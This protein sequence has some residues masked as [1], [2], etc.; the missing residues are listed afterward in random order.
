VVIE[1]AAEAGGARYKGKSAGALGDMGAFSLYVAH[2]I[3]T[4]DGGL[5]STDRED[6][7]EVLRS[8]R[9]HGRACACKTCVSTV[10]GGEC[11]KRFADAAVGD[12]R[13]HFERLGYSSRM[14]DLEAALGLGTSELYQQIIEARHRNLMA[15][16]KGFEKFGEFF[17]TYKEE[18]YERIGPHAFPFVVKPQAPFTRDDCLLH[19]A[20][21]GIDPRT[22]FS[23]IPTQCGGYGFLG[24]SPGD[25]PNSEYVGLNG[26]H[27]G[28]HQDVRLEDVAYFLDVVEDFIRKH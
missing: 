22:L 16:I 6:Y 18:P 28:V 4:G 10:S 9:A 20:R 19:L 3:T 26:L 11:R 7:A 12:R 27:I 21:H 25:F 2:I 13:F 23:S 1:D 24:Y 8:L 15:C 14:N 17:W 5:V